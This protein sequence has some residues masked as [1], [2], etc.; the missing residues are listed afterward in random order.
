[1]LFENMPSALTQ[2]FR[3]GRG[4]PSSQNL[5][6]YWE[7]TLLFPHQRYVETHL[8]SCDFC[9]AELQLLTRYPDQP[10][11][12]FSVEMPLQLRRFAEHLLRRSSGSIGVFSET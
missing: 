7:S 2:L 4:C 1:M 12:Y 9:R 11:E 3:K 6:A 8:R 5:L 10:E